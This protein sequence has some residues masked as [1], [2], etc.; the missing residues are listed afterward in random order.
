MVQPTTPTEIPTLFY[1]HKQ[2]VCLA[3]RTQQVEENLPTTDTH[4]NVN[5]EEEIIN[6]T[7]NVDCEINDEDE[8]DNEV[9]MEAHVRNPNFNKVT[10]VLETIKL[11]LMYRDINTDIKSIEFQI[12]RKHV[13]SLQDARTD[14]FFQ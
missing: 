1:Q 4:A 11:C 6:G 8:D 12:M 2:W 3:W 14:S 13:A 5:W 7:S 9:E 10:N